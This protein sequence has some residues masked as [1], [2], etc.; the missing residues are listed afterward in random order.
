MAVES[1]WSGLN[2]TGGSRLLAIEVVL[3]GGENPGNKLVTLCSI[4]VLLF[5]G[6]RWFCVCLDT[7]GS[8]SSSVI[9]C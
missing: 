2:L 7:A 4:T 9:S 6:F 1:E 8:Y 3:V 5:S